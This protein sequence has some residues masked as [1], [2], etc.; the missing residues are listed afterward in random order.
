MCLNQLKPNCSYPSFLNKTYKRCPVIP[1]KEGS[2]AATISGQPS[3][4]TTSWR[5]LPVE[6][7]L[8][9]EKLRKE[10]RE[11]VSNAQESMFSVSDFVKR[12]A[13]LIAQEPLNYTFH[14]FF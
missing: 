7:I 9:S 6:R 5:R 11:T 1:V 14:H 13:S 2:Y 10:L 3:T 4:H 12:A 8:P